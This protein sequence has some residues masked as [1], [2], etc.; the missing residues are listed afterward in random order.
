MRKCLYECRVK[1]TRVIAKGM[2]VTYDGECC[3]MIECGPYQT[4]VTA[5]PGETVVLQHAQGHAVAVN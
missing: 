1:E 3:L 4:A 5:Y 2:K